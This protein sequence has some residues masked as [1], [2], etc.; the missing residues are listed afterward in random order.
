MPIEPVT[1]QLPDCFATSLTASAK[2][3]DRWYKTARAIPATRSNRNAVLLFAPGTFKLTFAKSLSVF[4]N[5][6]RPRRPF[7]IGIFGCTSSAVRSAGAQGDSTPLPGLQRQRRPEAASSSHFR[8]VFAAR[9][10]AANTLF[11]SAISNDSPYTPV[12]SPSA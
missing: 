1:T 10:A 11:T 7:E 8:R 2:H 12:R 3:R 9:N 5:N 6:L 4:E